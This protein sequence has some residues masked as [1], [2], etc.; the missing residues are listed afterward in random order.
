LNKD[1]KARWI[2]E[3]LST[4]HTKGRYQLRDANGISPGGI[5]CELAVEDGIIDPPK[6][7]TQKTGRDA[8]MFFGYT[9]EGEGVGIPEAVAKWA[10]ISFRSV[11][12]L[13]YLSDCGKSFEE[14]AEYIKERY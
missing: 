2:E 7:L 12:R 6:D 3:L 11:W 1:I 4:R 10:G 5:L 9:Y 14:T 13:D 8:P